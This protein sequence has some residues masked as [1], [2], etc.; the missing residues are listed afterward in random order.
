M[1]KFGIRNGV[2]R[3]Q[4]K[5]CK[6]T[7]SDSPPNP[8]G[9]LHV[10][11]EKAVEVVSLLCE[12]TGIRACERLSGVHRDTVMHIL[13]MAGQKAAAFMD[14]RIRNV[15]AEWIQA[16]E[17]HTFVYSKQINTP[18]TQNLR[19]EQYAFLSVDRRSKL[20]INWLVGKHSRENAEFF[21]MDLKSRVSNRFQLTTDN[22]A[23]YSGYK[24]AVEAILG[25]ET[26]YATETKYFAK[27]AV[28]VAR[29]LVGIR[30]HRRIGN[31]D[32]RMATTSHVE[33][34]NLSVRQFAR[35]FT[36]CTLGFSKKLDNLKH[37]VALF[38]WH[39]NFVRVHGAYGV[40]PAYA[41]GIA[42]REPMK[43]EDL[44]NFEEKN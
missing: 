4:C 20:I 29:Q 19:G 3:Y 31:P 28:F 27:P 12:S 32:L 41:A 16:D 30:R 23:V 10:P 38:V 5:I 18:E 24:G 13:E 35:R 7:Q 26:D 37:A 6:R 43:I 21:L 2:Q 14:A 36:R 9:N 42:P 8:L 17:V 15:T 33:R 22:W 1:V 34:T 11:F 39:F 40:T 44:L 25:N